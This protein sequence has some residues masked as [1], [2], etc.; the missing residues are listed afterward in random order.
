MKSLSQKS[1]K[2]FFGAAIRVVTLAL[3]LAVFGAG[4][5]LAQTR[6]YVANN[7]ANTISVMDPATN[8]IVATIPVGARPQGIAVTPNGAFAYTANFSDNT[9]SVISAATNTVVATV[10]VG[11][12]PTG[13]A[14]TPNGA[15]AY[16]TNNGDDTVSVINTAT[17]TVAVTIP[18]IGGPI[19]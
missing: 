8:T 15:F 13:I 14:I 16:V 5:A 4:A 12:Q 2:Q 3:F 11:A 7:V 6:A 9:V 18:G 17:D 10:P 1:S 19:L